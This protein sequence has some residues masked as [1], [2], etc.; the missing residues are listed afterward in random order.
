MQ[1][2]NVDGANLECMIQGHREAEPVLFIHGSVIANANAP[3]IEQPIFMNR[4][5]Y[6][7]SYY[8]RGFAESH[9]LMLAVS[10]S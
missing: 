6:L 10:S 5:Y 4:C 7:I 9:F 2:V 8:R 1:Y 3:L